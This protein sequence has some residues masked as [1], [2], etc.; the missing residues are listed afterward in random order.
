MKSRM[1]VGAAIA[2]LC[3]TLFAAGCKN[4]AGMEPGS[5][6]R[7]TDSKGNEYIVEHELLEVYRVKRILR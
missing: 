1:K 5:I 2:V 3:S 4:E 7:V 6:M